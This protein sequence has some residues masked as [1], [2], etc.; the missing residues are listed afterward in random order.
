MKR[1]VFVV[2]VFVLLVFS[3]GFVS[4]GFFD[5]FRDFFG[6]TGQQVSCENECS[7]STSSLG[8]SGGGY[9]QCVQD[10]NGCWSWSSW[11]CDCASGETCNQG[12]CAC[13]D[14]CTSGSIECV[15]D[16]L[17]R[18]C[19]DFDSDSCV[20]WK[21]IACESGETCSE[22]SCVAVQSCT[23]TDGSDSSTKDNSKK[24]TTCDVFGACVTDSCES[25]GDLFEGYCD[26]GV[27][28]VKTSIVS[29]GGAGSCADGVCV[30]SS[31]GSTSVG[32]S[33]TTTSTTGS[34]ST[35]STTTGSSGGASGGGGGGATGGSSGGGSSGGASSGGSTGGGGSGPVLA[36]GEVTKNTESRSFIDEDGNDVRVESSETFRTDGGSTRKEERRFIDGRGREVKEVKVE[37][38]FRG[39]GTRKSIENRKFINN[40]GKEVLI[41]IEIET[42]DGS[43]SVKREI[44]VDGEVVSVDSKVELTEK[45]VDGDV[46][47]NAKLSNGDER[48]VGV[49]PDEVK[50]IVERE[51][52]NRDFEIKLEEE[53]G[54]SGGV[55]VVYVAEVNRVRRLFGLFEVPT[56]ERVKVGV[57]GGV[58]SVDKPW[59]AFF[60]R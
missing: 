55:D 17:Y 56:K 43:I 1:G 47:V 28:S 39:D 32:S 44:T 26:G 11:V 8:A 40:N 29:C 3:T 57:D 30:S 13:E 9:Y 24:D 31:S 15:G 12:V 5:W 4:A 50:N 33:G 19:G 7:G 52:G 41:V 2:A 25:D 58:I 49:L 18:T 35:T 27:G 23:R 10:S 34:G 14:E 48:T 60:S 36:E 54:E 37:T 20:E 53:A 21:N 22:G 42:K 46:V 6:I 38:E 45:I 59:W 16:S 51:V